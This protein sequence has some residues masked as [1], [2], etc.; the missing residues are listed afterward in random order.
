VPAIVSQVASLEEIVG[1]AAYF[2]NPID[3]EGIAEA[4][5]K[6]SQDENMREEFRQ[7]GLER[8][9]KF[10]WEDVAKK[11]LALYEKINS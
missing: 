4:M 10:N 6:F 11:T 8:A 7:R 3:V 5:L 9:K 1:D 2:V